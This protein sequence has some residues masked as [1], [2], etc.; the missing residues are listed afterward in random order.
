MSPEA[1]FGLRVVRNVAIGVVLLSL[2][3]M[4]PMSSARA[5]AVGLLLAFCIVNACFD[6]AHWQA[7]DEAARERDE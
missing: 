3:L 5:T 7:D 6:L 4:V 2:V 1:R